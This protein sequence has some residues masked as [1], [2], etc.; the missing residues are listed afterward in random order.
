MLTAAINSLRHGI[1]F[2]FYIIN[3]PYLKRTMFLTL[4]WSCLWVITQN[5]SVDRIAR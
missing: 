3:A 2:M 5:I 1:H 4:C